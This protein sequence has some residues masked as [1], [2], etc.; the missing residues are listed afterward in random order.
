MTTETKEVKENK[1]KYDVVLHR[2]GQALCDALG[3][4]DEQQIAKVHLALKEATVESWK[5][6]IQAGFT[7]GVKAKQAETTPSA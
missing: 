3:L 7:R 5:N 2:R 4:T 1:E 6:G